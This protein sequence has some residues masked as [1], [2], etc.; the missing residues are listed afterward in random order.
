MSLYTITYESEQL[1]TENEVVSA[2]EWNV[3]QVYVLADS[4][5]EACRKFSDVYPNATIKSVFVVADGI[6]T[7]IIV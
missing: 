3:P 5:S 6:K 7:K 2:T 4:L 1:L